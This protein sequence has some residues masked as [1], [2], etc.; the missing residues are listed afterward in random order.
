LI[1]LSSSLLSK[2]HLFPDYFNWT[3]A[4]GLY[5]TGKWPLEEERFANRLVLEFEAGVLEDCKDGC[6]LRSYLAK[7][8]RCAPMR[9]SKKFAGK[10]IG[11]KAF[12]RR[13]GDRKSFLE[14]IIAGELNIAR[15]QKRPTQ[16]SERR[17]KHVMPLSKSDLTDDEDS[18][19][20][21]NDAVD[22]NEPSSPDSESTQVKKLVMIKR[23]SKTM[24]KKII[25]PQSKSIDTPLVTD[26]FFHCSLPE[27]ENNAL[28]LNPVHTSSYEYGSSSFYLFDAADPVRED[29]S[30]YDIDEGYEEW[31]EALSYFKE[32][33]SFSNANGFL[34]SESNMSLTS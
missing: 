15:L 21:S 13:E 4:E 18:S 28:N 1:N 29:K 8:L 14:K 19:Q 24:K 6:T 5:H 34:R 17:S 30:Q 26:I 32:T 2:F 33:D 9:V 25:N 20:G 7:T 23:F 16:K 31:C 10:C 11:S 27:P 22:P 3:I 12:C